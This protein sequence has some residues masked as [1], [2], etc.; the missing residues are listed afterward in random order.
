MIRSRALLGTLVGAALLIVAATAGCDRL[1]VWSAP[2]K[3][4]SAAR[5]AAAVEADKLFWKTLHGGEYDRIPDAL[6][7]VKA[8][9]LE[10]PHDAV[11]AA[12]VGWLH[13]WRLAERARQASQRPDIT[14]DAVLARK[15]FE[16]AV[17]LDPREARYL[18]FYA[19]LL[20]AE[21]T[22]HKDEKLVRRGFYAMKDAIA[23]W[24]EFNYFT[25]G[26]TASGL[27]VDSDRFR[28][29]LAQQWLNLDVC[30]G[31]KVDRAN[32]D[33]ARYMRLETR[34]GAKRVCW[35]SWIAPH[36]FEGFFLNFGDMLVK[37]GQPDLAVA[38]YGNARRARGYAAWPYRAV[39]EARI[40]DAATNV[41]AF[42]RTEPG[43][44]AAT[45]MVRSTF[46]CMGCHQR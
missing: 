14:D 46:A 42:R 16:E 40:R 31:E 25:A 41:A 35:N 2:A 37:A 43:P 3:A 44:D 18:G 21:G 7:A 27:P 22:I 45:L 33:Y 5:T 23:A 34:E 8:A 39:L 4:P 26:Y 24:P 32:P 17:R 9:Y 19:G 13:T 30:T 11:T 1:A 36:N 15:Y 20:M 28:E 12:H 10:N 38:M 29:A 6:T